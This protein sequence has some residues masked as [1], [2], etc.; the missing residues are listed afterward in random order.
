[1]L[2]WIFD[3]D[4]T[5]YNISKNKEFNYKLLKGDRQLNYLIKQLPMKKIIFT[6]G[7]YLH[8]VHCTKLLKI[9]D[10]F[11]NMTARDTIMDLKPNYDAYHK[12]NKLNNIYSKDK[13]VFFEDSIDNL[14]IAKEFGWI[15]VLIGPKKYIHE[16]ID[17]YFPTIHIALN[18]FN[19]KIQN[20][21]K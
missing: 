7:T 17:F 5:L 1:M 9:D 21:I 15:T 11:D 20:Y 16:S 6:N 18:F 4:Y 12:F 13:C 2:Y 10:C 14:I 19:T 3:L 8:G